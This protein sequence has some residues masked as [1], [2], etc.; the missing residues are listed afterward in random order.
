MLQYS[1]AEVSVWVNDEV[2]HTSASPLPTPR[3]PVYLKRASPRPP[4]LRYAKHAHKLNTYSKQAQTADGTNTA[5]Q[6]SIAGWLIGHT[7]CRNFN[8]QFLIILYIA[9]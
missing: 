5:V 7:V 2:L 8:L 3:W 6:T 9:R 4:F 1:A